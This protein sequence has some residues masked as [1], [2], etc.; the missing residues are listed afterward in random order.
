MLSVAKKLLSLSLFHWKCLSAYFRPGAR[1]TMGTPF[2]ILQRLGY[3]FSNWCYSL[4]VYTAE[5]LRFMAYRRLKRVD[6]QLFRHYFYPNQ[7]W[8][9][10]TEG[11]KVEAPETLYRLTYGETTWF[12]IDAMLKKVKA[13]PHDVFYDLGC[14]TGRNVFFASIVYG[15]QA[16]GVDLLTS[17]VTFASQTAAENKLSQT[18][19]LQQNIFETPL[20]AA[21]I[22]FVT[23]N[24]YDQQTMPLLVKRFEDLR[25]GTR[26]ISTHRS[27]P[28]PRLTVTGS[29]RLPFSWGVDR[30]YY[31]EV[32]DLTAQA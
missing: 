19:F 6:S 10:L 17:F 4:F 22:V 21:S 3:Y 1:W 29:Q 12:G 28:S 23:A 7:F 26:V 16:V 30:V 9:A 14:G 20:Q 31:H 13:G 24:C 27:I 5:A 11:L 8:I 25:P 2:H 32:S 18:R 15:M